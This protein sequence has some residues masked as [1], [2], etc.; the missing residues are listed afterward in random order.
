M[1]DISSCLEFTI[2]KLRKWRGLLVSIISNE[3]NKSIGVTDRGQERET[4]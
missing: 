1:E 2:Q 4:N 3:F